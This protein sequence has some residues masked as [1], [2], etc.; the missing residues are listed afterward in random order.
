M[1]AD[2]LEE[3]I[4]LFAA[5]A[6][7]QAMAAA[8]AADVRGHK[9]KREEVY[10]IRNNVWENVLDLPFDGWYRTNLRMSRKTFDL[11]FK[12]VSSYAVVAE[13]ST[14]ARNA[15][16]DLRMQIAMTLA[17]LSQEGGFL[18]TASLFGVSKST[19][20]KAVHRILDLLNG[21]A[22]LIIW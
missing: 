16:V 10:T 12:T 22:Q 6:C 14:P 15:F 2:D 19:T 13:N 8:A 18:P 1:N 4:V 5:F 11:V 20:I 21:L 9:R 7:F 17:Y 3:S